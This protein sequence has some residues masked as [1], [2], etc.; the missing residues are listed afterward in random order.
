[1]T[2]RC[3]M[4]LTQGFISKVKVTVHTY[5]KSGHNSSLSSVTLIIFYTIVFHD[6][7]MCHDFDPRSYLR[8]QGHSA[9]IPKTVS[10]PQL[11]NA[12]LDLDNISHNFC[13]WPN[14]VSWPWPKVLSPRS[15]SQCTHTQNLCPCCPGHNSSLSSVTLIIFYT[16]PKKKI[17]VFTVTCWKKLGSVGRKW[18]FF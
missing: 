2:Q 1:M 15:R 7:R 17:C 8:S 4:T 5:P 12:K 6:P 18:F 11:L 16:R 9:H 3:V 14:D 10:W 13:P